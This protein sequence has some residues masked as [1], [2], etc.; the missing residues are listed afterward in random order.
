MRHLQTGLTLFDQNLATPGYTLFSPMG[1]KRSLLIDLHGEIVHEWRLPGYTGIYSHLL[2]NGNL[3]AGVQTP[4]GP[5]VNPTPD[6]VLSA[7]N[8]LVMLGGAE[9][10]ADFRKTF[11]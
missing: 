10:H 9:Q 6:T 4:D 2:P 5:A 1:A 8:E 7:G 11:A 3:L